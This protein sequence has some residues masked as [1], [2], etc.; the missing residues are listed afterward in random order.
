MMPDKRNIQDEHNRVALLTIEVGRAEVAVK[1][2]KRALDEWEKALIANNP[3]KGE[4]DKNGDTRKAWVTNLPVTDPQCRA[5]RQVLHEEEI[6]LM[7]LETAVKAAGLIKQGV[8]W[9]VRKLIVDT[10]RMVYGQEPA[11][12]ESAANAALEK[13][14]RNLMDEAMRD[15][16]RAETAPSLVEPGEQK[17]WVTSE[18]VTEGPLKPIPDGNGA[19]QAQERFKA[20]DEAIDRQMDGGGFGGPSVATAIR[21]VDES[22]ALDLTR[23]PDFLSPE[24]FGD[25][26]IPF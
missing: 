19:I 10:L 14:L 7:H 11:N 26:D 5:L 4:H 3:P 12:I 6:R 20:F 24:D 1:D 17:D 8:E 9:S 13:G 2:A 18:W 16:Q 22:P 21:H 23:L 25:E 15:V